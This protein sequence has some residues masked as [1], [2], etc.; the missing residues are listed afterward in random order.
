M[1][2]TLNTIELEQG[3]YRVTVASQ[4]IILVDVILASHE[5]LG[6]LLNTVAS[7]AKRL[8]V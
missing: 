8:S 3:R 5:E 2:L 4:D 1:T 7:E 6:E